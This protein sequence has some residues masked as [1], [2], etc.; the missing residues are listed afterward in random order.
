MTSYNSFGIQFKYREESITFRSTEDNTVTPDNLKEINS[1][2]PMEDGFINSRVTARNLLFITL[3]ANRNLEKLF[4]FLKFIQDRFIPFSDNL[5]AIGTIESGQ[6][7]L[8]HSNTIYT[9]KGYI[10]IVSREVNFRWS[11]NSTIKYKI[12]DIEGKLYD[13]YFENGTHKNEPAYDIYRFQ[14]EHAEVLEGV[15]TRLTDLL[16]NILKLNEK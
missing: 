12:L 10:F 15:V 8:Y 9:Y 6:L 13:H 5:Q 4:K 11:E 2:L 16:D 1:F 7:Q 3:A 14:D